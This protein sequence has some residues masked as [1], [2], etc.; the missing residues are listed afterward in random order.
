MSKEEI[1]RP[2][3]YIAVCESPVSYFNRECQQLA[4]DYMK[5]LN[6][7]HATGFDS[8]SAPRIKKDLKTPMIKLVDGMFVCI[9][10][11]NLLN[12]SIGD[13]V[14]PF[15]MWCKYKFKDRYRKAMWFVEYEIRGKPLPYFRVGIKYF[16]LINKIDRNGIERRE[17]KAWD[18]QTILDDYDKDY[19]AKIPKYDDFTI[20]PNN[21]GDI[22]ERGENY[23]L[24]A[25]FEHEPKKSS[26]ESDIFWTTKFLKHI[27]G[28]QYELGITY[29][30]VLYDLPTQ[31]L[32]ILVLTSEDRGTGKTTFIDYLEML[33]GANTVIINPQDISSSF[34]YNYAVSNII[35][36]EESRFESLQATEKLKNLSTQKKILVN[37]KFVQQYS[38]PFHGKIIITSNDENKFSKVDEKEIRYWVRKVP[39]IED[40]ANHSILKDMKKEIPYFLAYLNSLP[41]I[42]TSKSRMVFSQENL[43]TDALETVK[44]ESRSWLHKEIIAL[45]E[46]HFDANMGIKKIEF[47]AKDLK[48]K[49]FSRNNNAEVSYIN[50]V[51]KNEMNLK[52]QKMKRYVPLKEENVLGKKK[53]GTPYYIE[54]ENYDPNSSKIRTFRAEPD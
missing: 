44:K 45:T 30:K 48:D 52:R 10:N 43:V 33:F 21:K 18:K 17:V 32:P 40:K 24:Y 13:V 9:H 29:I 22:I 28:E 4:L 39:V 47:T 42:D 3:P 41:D 20:E 23:N 31:K 54:N 37:S 5:G 25:P 46:E 16:K 6:F 34:N 36:I 38:I 26:K 14:D 49:W 27:F 7:C 53:S 2:S 35:M 50:F 8:F 51:I 19:L 11:D 12:M 15:T 1:K